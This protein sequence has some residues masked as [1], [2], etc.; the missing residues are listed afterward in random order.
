MQRLQERPR[1]QRRRLHTD[2][3]NFGTCQARA[4]CATAG[5]ALRTPGR[6]RP[7]RDPGRGRRGRDRPRRAHLRSALAAARARGASIQA[8]QNVGDPLRRLATVLEAI[9]VLERCAGGLLREGAER[10]GGVR[11]RCGRRGCELGCCGSLGKPARSRSMRYDR[12]GEPDGSKQRRGSPHWCNGRC[13]WSRGRCTPAPFDVC[14]R[15][16]QKRMSC[17]DNACSHARPQRTSAASLCQTASAPA[18]SGEWRSRGCHAERCRPAPAASVAAPPRPLPLSAT[19]P[20][21]A[22]SPC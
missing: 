19:S 1:V 18:P 11:R 13:V 7:R 6:A 4:V 17:N 20:S 3:S 21:P 14:D 15:R 9:R 5:R 22:P 10:S 16:V 2:L 12:R 8:L